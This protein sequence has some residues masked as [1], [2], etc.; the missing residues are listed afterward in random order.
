MSKPLLE[1]EGNM[2]QMGITFNQRGEWLYNIKAN[3]KDRALNNIVEFMKSYLYGD[4]TF[5]DKVENEEVSCGCC[6]K[7]NLTEETKAAYREVIE[8]IIGRL[9]AG[10]MIETNI[11]YERLGMIEK[12][13]SDRYKGI[14]KKLNDLIEEA[15]IYSDKD[16]EYL[17][18]MFIGIAVEKA[19]IPVFQLRHKSEFEKDEC[20][21]G[22]RL[23]GYNEKLLKEFLLKSLDRGRYFVLDTMEY[24]ELSQY[25]VPVTYFE[26]LRITE[27]VESLKGVF[28]LFIW[29]LAAGLME[30]NLTLKALTPDQLV[31]CEKKQLRRAVELL[32][33]D[34]KEEW[35]TYGDMILNMD[36]LYGSQSV[37][38][39]IKNY[40]K[41]DIEKYEKIDIGTVKTM[42]KSLCII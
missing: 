32:N 17:Y 30:H 37:E 3:L 25:K 18:E 22:Y 39:M 14:S 5:R 35:I 8:D 15:D 1:G 26:V 38:S 7:E 31:K 29:L 27:P 19:S 42:M 13:S 23:Y 9:E 34:I 10:V 21:Y 41:Y 11:F 20:G 4:S 6:I 28:G 24:R 33:H 12:L 36:K 2:N 16:K 40:F